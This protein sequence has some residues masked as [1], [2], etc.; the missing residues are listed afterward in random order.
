M[1]K[2]EESAFGFSDVIAFLVVVLL[3]FIIVG[4]I[5]LQIVENRIESRLE[6]R[7]NMQF[8][9]VEDQL[10][11]RITKRLLNNENFL[12]LSEWT[13][14]CYEENVTTKHS[15]IEPS[16]SGCEDMCGTEEIEVVSGK[17]NICGWESNGDINCGWIDNKK[18]LT[19]TKEPCYSSCKDIKMSTVSEPFIHYWNET[20]CVKEILVKNK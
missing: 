3:A 4:A 10:E 14:E 20:K 19:Q 2:K 15:M 5:F 17:I 6:E 9:H 11:K 8:F 16:E 12:D 18:I 13:H 7:V 1:A